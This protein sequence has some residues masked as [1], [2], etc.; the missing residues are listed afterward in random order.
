MGG[1]RGTLPYVGCTARDD[2]HCS[3]FRDKDENRMNKI[4]MVRL[5][6]LFSF[7]VG[8]V[9]IPINIILG[10]GFWVLSLYGFG[11]RTSCQKAIE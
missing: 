9:L 7:L 10:V 6:A 5:T 4:E 8:C 11:I 2:F 3:E 1:V